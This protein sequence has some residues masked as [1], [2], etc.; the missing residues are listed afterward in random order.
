[1]I[2]HLGF[3][4]RSI[5]GY[6]NH[7][8]ETHRANAAKIK[9]KLDNKTREELQPF[10]LSS[11]NKMDMI[12][13]IGQN[14]RAVGMLFDEVR[15]M[16]VDSED[17]MESLQKIISSINVAKDFKALLPDGL[18]AHFVVAPSADE[19]MGRTL[20]R[21]GVRNLTGLGREMQT[22][23]DAFKIGQTTGSKNTL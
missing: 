16:G 4:S 8:D 22:I 2:S 5:S 9:S 6:G 15:L 12:Q 21:D 23:S 7:A 13:F 19:P 18:L 10:L 3:S 14:E 11:P 20:H 1:M 17:K